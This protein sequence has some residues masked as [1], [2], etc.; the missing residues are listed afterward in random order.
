MPSPD[1]H[2]DAQFARETPLTYGTWGRFKRLYKAVEKAVEADAPAGAALFG[3]LAARLDAAPLIS[4]A[5]ALPVEMGPDVRGV[6]S[7]AVVGRGVYCL[8]TKSQRQ[9]QFAGYEF[10]PENP[11]R[12]ALVGSVDAPGIS[13]LIPFGPFLCLVGGARGAETLSVFDPDASSGPQWRGTIAL[14]GSS[15]VVGAG[16]YVYASVYGASQGQRSAWSGLRILDLTNPDQPQIAGELEIKEVQKVA[17]DGSLVAV[18]SGQTR[19]QWGQAPGVSAVSFV[20]ASNPRRPRL[21]STLQ[22]NPISAVA[23]RG[24][25]VAL[26]GPLAFV[27]V[28]RTSPQDFAGLQ[29]VDISDPSHPR[30]LGFFATRYYPPQ[31][32]TLHGD[33]AYLTFQYG[34]PQIVNVSNPDAPT[35]AGQIQSNNVSALAV[36]EDTAYVGTN[37]RGL[38]LYSVK[39]PGKPARIGVPPSGATLGYMKRRVRRVLRHFAK[40][41][42]NAYVSLAAAVLAE[43]RSDNPAGI[44]AARQWVLAD[45]LYGGGSRYT[46]RRHGRGPL[47]AAT[48]APRRRREERAPEAWDTHLDTAAT[49]LLT[50]ALPWFVHEAMAKILGANNAS[51]PSPSSESLAGFLAAPSA[52][53]NHFAV[54][55]A[56]ARMEQGEIV[57]PETAALAF[58]KASAKWRRMIE[59]AL[60]SQ[61]RYAEDAVWARAF[62]L[63]VLMLAY[64]S[65]QNGRLSRR[66][67]GAC[68][69]VARR[70]PA[71]VPDALIRTLAAAFLT[72]NRPGL[73]DLVLAIARRVTPPAALNWLQALGPVA[74]DLRE[75]AV[76][77]L[78]FGLVPHGFTLAEA[79][80]LVLQQS[81]EF[82]RVAGWR[83]L[84]ASDTA[85]AVFQTLWT[86]LLDSA[87]ETFAL[88]TAMSSPSALATLA[89]AGFSPQTIADRLRERPFLAGLLSPQTFATLL[90]SVPPSVALA[91]IAAVAD[92]RW[93]EFR[94]F[95]LEYLRSG[96][97]LDAFWNAA[98]GALDADAKGRL[99]SRL[100]GDVG[101]ADTLALVDDPEVLSVRD[102]AFD[103][104]LARW[105]RAH[106]ALFTQNSLLLLQ[107]AIHVLPAVRAWGLGR[108]QALGFD[109]PFALRLLE[110]SLPASAEAGGAFFASLPSGDQAERGYA[111]A[112]CDSPIAPVRAS[113][114]TFVSQRWDRLPQDDLLRALFENSHPDMQAFVA[115]LLAS[116][117]AS[118]AESAQFDGEVLRARHTARRAKE[119]IKARQSA[120]PT[121][122][123]P[124]L[125]ALARSRT[126]RDSEWA[127]GQ[128]AK[129]ALAGQEID[130]FS[131]SGVAGG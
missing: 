75:P 58:V 17:C 97:G 30:K 39:N 20:D 111:L 85:P 60:D 56:A 68:E 126:P 121:V 3:A 87:S 27:G 123:V 12:P 23:L 73:I 50:P 125:L 112:L 14:G 7:I 86:G 48:P 66:Y 29:I 18:T 2:D 59:A 127:L 57:A 41:N 5:P 78:A 84:A 101:A 131:V 91:L 118:S 100:L 79:S 45:I 116:S 120:A 10:D 98:P 102:P 44:D 51:P 52:L 83:L 81:S 94:P 115:E 88:R 109:L 76:L 61:P 38:E 47:T 130:G 26:R 74:D 11:L 55:L 40:I 54:P 32:I 43:A 46:Q 15:T 77:A 105:V 63:K 65:L 64:A 119:K 82:L 8:V 9:T 37:Y 96:S 71:L 70:F 49:L 34:P 93:P 33:F 6:S 128:L 42:P 35:A 69:M 19:F 104:A 67:A 25:S 89:R 114:R 13:S 31:S 124:T 113:G 103:A 36:S 80:A 21:L 122:D 95:L 99:E 92:D 110:S 62:T 106:E 22:F 1:A 72:A 107:A 108:A 24:S 129:L 28:D 53:L 4:H 16:S 90:P 117:P